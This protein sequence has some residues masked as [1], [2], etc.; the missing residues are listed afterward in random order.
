MDKME[1]IVENANKERKAKMNKI[2]NKQVKVQ[3]IIICVMTA[4]IVI[5]LSFAVV[6][7]VAYVKLS[8]KATSLQYENENL[9]TYVTELERSYTDGNEK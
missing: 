7:R 8:E 2:L 4:I 9:H 3:N 1:Q 6:E 5:L